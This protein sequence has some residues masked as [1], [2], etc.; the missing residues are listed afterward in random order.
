MQ[1]KKQTLW[2]PFPFWKHL[3]RASLKCTPTA[4]L[5]L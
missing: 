2:R 5:A 4:R 1:M 3:G